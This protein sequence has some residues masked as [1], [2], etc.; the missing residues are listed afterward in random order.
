MVTRDPPNMEH[1]LMY[2]ST[3]FK[4]KLGAPIN[5]VILKMYPHLHISCPLSGICQLFSK[6]LYSCCSFSFYLLHSWCTLQSVEHSSTS[7]SLGLLV[8]GQNLNFEK[9]ACLP[10]LNQCVSAETKRSSVNMKVTTKKL[11]LIM[12]FFF[13]SNQFSCSAPQEGAK[14]LYIQAR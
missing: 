9:H 2:M 10:G 1:S 6:V 4:H 12:G 3:L 7:T 13:K 11:F 8:K 14:T 5:V